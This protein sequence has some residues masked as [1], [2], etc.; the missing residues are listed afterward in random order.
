MVLQRVHTVATSWEVMKLSRHMSLFLLLFL[1]A[2]SV[3]SLEV[4]MSIVER[5]TQLLPQVT[6]NKQSVVLPLNTMGLS[7]VS[8]E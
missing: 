3:Q 7:P 2:L 1:L 8:S 4:T 6:T 5:L